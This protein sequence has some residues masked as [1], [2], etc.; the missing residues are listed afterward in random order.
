MAMSAQHKAA[1]A[2]GR[3]ESR[4]IK[5]YLEA[6][7][8]KRPGRPITAESLQAKIE[9]LDQKIEAE[10]D[11]LARLE[12]RQQRLDAED[13]LKDVAR[14][15]DFADLEAEFVNYAGSY[16]ERKGISYT[17]WRDSG[18]P[19]AVLREAGVPRTRRT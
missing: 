11:P 9:T 5:A 16:S 4:A 8:S 18:V 13:A 17:A 6:L 1:L 7:E 3:K 19:A 2:Q 10:K 12:L 14:Q 15:A